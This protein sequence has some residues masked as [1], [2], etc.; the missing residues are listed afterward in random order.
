M[1][2]YSTRFEVLLGKLPTFDKEWAKTQFIWELHQRIAE[3]VIITG[4]SDL[5]ATRNNAEKVEMGRNLA[6]SGQGGQR[7]PM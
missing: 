4:P 3:L 1:R 2:S 7:P 6:A 5:H